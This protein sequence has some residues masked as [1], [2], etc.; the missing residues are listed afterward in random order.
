MKHILMV[1]A[2]FLSC[3]FS[4]AAYAQGKPGEGA[5]PAFVGQWTGVKD[6]N[7]HQDTPYDGAAT[8]DLR[9]DGTFIDNA[10]ETGWWSASG[11]HLTFQYSGGGATEFTG[12]LVGDVVVGTM[13]NS[14]SSYTGAFAI[15]RP[16]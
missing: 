7:G 8:W 14:D 13:H 16:Q 5:P 3:C 10:N 4:A 1:L 12:T 11:A 15:W 2:A 6:F 9:P